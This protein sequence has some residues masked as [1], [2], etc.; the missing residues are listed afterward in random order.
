MRLYELAARYDQLL[1]LAEE[2]DDS[3]ELV[4]A[5]DAQLEAIDQK[6]SNI[7]IM[8][9]TLDAEAEA[10]KAEEQRLTAKRKRLEKNAEKLREYLRANMTACGITRIKS[11]VFSISLSEGPMRV[12]ITDPDAVPPE[13][14]RTKTVSEPD[15][16][17][18]LGVYTVEGECV[19]G[20]RVERGTRLMIR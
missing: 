16:T 17:A 3:D 20:T 13:Y 14:R 5:L 19:P 12:V 8:L 9:R 6:G 7:A 2:G 18:I 15:K 1:S 10:V 11:D 4:A